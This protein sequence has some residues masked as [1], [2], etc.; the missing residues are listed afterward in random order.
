MYIETDDY[1]LPAFY[2]DPQLAP[3]KRK[4]DVLSQKLRKN[5]IKNQQQ[6]QMIAQQDRK[7]Y[8][9]T[10]LAS[11]SSSG[12]SNLSS[13][14]SG[15]A[16]SSDLSSS[17]STSKPKKA[18][19]IAFL[20]DL[21]LYTDDTAN[22]IA[23]YNA[24]APFNKRS[25]VTKRILDIPIIQPWLNKVHYPSN[26]KLASQKLLKKWIKNKLRTEK[27]KVNNANDEFQQQKKCDLIKNIS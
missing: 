19:K 14:S 25:D 15:S 8:V 6:Q 4:K 11:L 27:E 10:L 2:F 3:I 20:S 17:S 12:S 9:N 24:P 7:Q 23:L 18:K 13:G 26:I 16:S 5:L 21:P 22:A 1:D